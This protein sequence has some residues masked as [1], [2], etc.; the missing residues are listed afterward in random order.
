MTQKE[1]KI[2]QETEANAYLNK[3]YHAR[4]RATEEVK[5]GYTYADHVEVMIDVYTHGERDAVMEWIAIYRL[6]KDLGIEPNYDHESHKL[7]A[8]ITE[9]VYEMFLGGNEE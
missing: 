9:S 2:L 1:I 7:A 6:M 8:K 5:N 3:V 4:T